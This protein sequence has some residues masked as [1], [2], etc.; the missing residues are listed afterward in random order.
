MRIVM[1]QLNV[2][3]GAIEANATR[4]IEAAESA[5]DSQQADLI[6]FPELTLTGYPPEDLLLRAEFVQRVA[7]AVQTIATTV[8]GITLVFGYPQ[9]RADGLYNCAGVWR[10]G[11]LLGEYDKWLLPNYSV[12]D[13]KRYFS[14]GERALVVDVAG[15][16]VGISICED[17]WFQAPAIATRE[18]GAELI[19]NLN[20]S[21]FHT[22]KMVEREA[23]VSKR[24]QENGLPILYCN[25]I[26]GQDELVFDGGSF[27]VAADG[28]LTQRAPFFAEEQVLVEFVQ[29]NG[30]LIPQPAAIARHD[31]E[32]AEIYACLVLGVR[33]YVQKNGFA[34]AL[35]GLSGGIDSALT[36]AIAVD[37]LGAESVEAV[38][39]PSRYTADMSNEDAAI[40]ADNLGVMTRLI[41]IEPAFRAF[42]G[43]LETE[44]NTLSP[45]A[46]DTTEE[47]LQARS[48][49]AILM[50]LSN[51]SGKILL[52]TGNKSEMAVG[53]A[54]L[55]G[56]MAGG[57]APIKDVPKML[58]YRLA[59]YRNSLSPV[60]PER[61]L[62]R[63]PSAELRPDQ[64]DS[65]SLPDYAILDQILWHYVEQDHSIAQ[66]IDAGFDA[67]TVKRVV[68]MV[69]TNEYKRRQ[70]PPGIKITRRA[71]GRDRRYPITNGFR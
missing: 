57:F 54:T 59:H 71:F 26:G 25:L 21:P 52:T 60:I 55:Y 8:T 46:G 64:R 20:A 16:K 50:A 29:Q 65:D 4:V 14:S 49:G 41:P 23:L 68:R 33:D 18:A 66:I 1:A 44:L 48:R 56:D 31:S 42:L 62:E 63:P 61:V 10:D 58:V 7:V 40:Q 35:L 51:R 2:L 70:A 11:T 39:M 13:E 27:V 19:V 36:L 67:E 6:V 38:L 47:N 3:V 22:G 12:F 32:E 37:A 28:R 30:Q 34:G 43:M 45:Q 69:D 9:Q 53:Y 15:V 17:I 24:A 5:R